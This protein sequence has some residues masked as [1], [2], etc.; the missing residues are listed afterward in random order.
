MTA[1]VTKA[2][3]E[4]VPGA[5]DAQTEHGTFEVILSAETQDRDGDT[6]K[7]TEWELPL[8]DH[9]TFDM[10]HGM[11]VAT[12]IGS[13]KPRI[14]DDGTLRVSGT[15]SSIARGQEVRTLVNEGHIRTTS[16]ACLTK[17]S[18]KGGRGVITRELLNG[19]FVAVPSNREAVV[20]SSKA[21]T[22]LEADVDT[23]AKITKAEHLQAA[24]DALAAAGAMC[25]AGEA[26]SADFGRVD[27]KSL[28]GSVEALQDR[29]RDAL[30]AEYGS[31]FAWMR[32]VIPD[33]AAGGVVVFEAR[34]A[35]IDTYECATYSQ[36]FA[37]DG[38]TVTLAGTAA[39]VGVQEIVVPEPEAQ[40]K[41]A[42]VPTPEAAAEDD[43][44]ELARR[45]LAIRAA[46][47][48]A[49]PL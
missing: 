5:D 4:I 38:A 12:T 40:L 34:P 28:V 14:A 20:I 32:G 37:D 1:V 8:P 6:F 22:A 27:L 2:I 44:S 10:D 46:A 31:R 26:K 21:Y 49:A 16:V 47:L 33:G 39:E 3:A 29:V 13:G 11:S 18:T 24:H 36:T 25:A 45:A 35:S 43:S 42:A 15:Y 30:R 19:A 48:A 41:S 9:I 17:K 23:K 7:S